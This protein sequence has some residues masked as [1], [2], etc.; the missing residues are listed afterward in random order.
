M[1]GFCDRRSFLTFTTAGFAG[2]LLGKAGLAEP[3]RRA[4]D[5]PTVLNN[6][7]WFQVRSPIIHPKV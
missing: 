2:A 6:I 5:K 1:C 7:V 3:S 4:V